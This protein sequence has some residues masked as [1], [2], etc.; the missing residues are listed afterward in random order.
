[1]AP[2]GSRRP[3]HRVGGTFSRMLDSSIRDALGAGSLFAAGVALDVA[4]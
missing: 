2:G 3:G 4:P 1:V